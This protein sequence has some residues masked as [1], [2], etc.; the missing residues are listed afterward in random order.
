MNQKQLAALRQTQLENAKRAADLLAFFINGG[1]DT[2][3]ADTESA[4]D[5]VVMTLALTEHLMPTAA[6]EAIL[7]EL[8]LERG[9]TPMGAPI[10]KRTA[11]SFPKRA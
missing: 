9:H 11:K 8:Q 6:F 10:L 5:A 7:Q 2:K 1:N 4:K 3:W